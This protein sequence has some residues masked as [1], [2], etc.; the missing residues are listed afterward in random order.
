MCIS[1][2]WLNHFKKNILRCKTNLYLSYLNIQN[3]YLQTIANIVIPICILFS[4]DFNQFSICF[5]LHLACSCVFLFSIPSFLYNLCCKSE[6]P[7]CLQHYKFFSCFPDKHN[8]ET[9]HNKECSWYVS[10]IEK[11]TN[12]AKQ[13]FP[14][15]TCITIQRETKLFIL[16]SLLYIISMCIMSCCHWCTHLMISI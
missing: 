12:K 10:I 2:E 11:N 15:S 13:Q 3:M 7:G 14:T 9:L 8:N 16:N 5:K 4:G 1:L 6:G